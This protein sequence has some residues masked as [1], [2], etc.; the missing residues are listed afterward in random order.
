MIVMIFLIDFF[1]LLLKSQT[2]FI[3]SANR[4]R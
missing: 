3:A 4:Q 2:F 1:E